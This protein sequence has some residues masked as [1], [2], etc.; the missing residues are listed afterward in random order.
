MN[1]PDVTFKNP[2]VGEDYEFTAQIDTHDPDE[3]GFGLELVVTYQDEKNITKVYD[4]KEFDVINSAGSQMNFK[5]KYNL[6]NGGNYK[7]G[8]R[9]FPKNPALPNRMNFCYVRWI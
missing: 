8:I 5:L 1:L 6:N 7:F 4:T 9:L 3:R 2:L